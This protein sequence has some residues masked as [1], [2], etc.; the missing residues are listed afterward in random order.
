MTTTRRIDQLAA[1]IA[2]LQAQLLALQALAKK[3]RRP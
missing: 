2:E 1:A 3:G